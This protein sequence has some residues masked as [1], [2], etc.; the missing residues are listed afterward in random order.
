VIDEYTTLEARDWERDYGFNSHG[1]A[2]H[3]RLPVFPASSLAGRPIPPRR[4]HVPKIIP[5]Q[6]VTLLGGD[7]G[8]GKSLLAKQLAVSTALGSPWLGLPVEQGKALFLT[9]EDDRD[10]IHRRLADIVADLG[11]DL[12]QLNRLHVVTLADKDDA[13]LAVP[14]KGTLRT[15][16]LFKQLEAAMEEIQPCFVALDTLADLFGGEE[17][18]RAHARQ[19]ISLLRGLAI[20]YDCTI[21]LLTHPSLSGMASGSGTSGSTAWSNSV[22]SRLYLDRVKNEDGQE[23]DQDV[24]ILRVMKANYDRTGDEYKVR[25]QNG[26]FVSATPAASAGQFSLIAAKDKADAIFLDLVAAYEVEKRTVS[27][28][29]PAFAPNVFARDARAEGITKRGLT[30]AMNRLFAAGR[31]EVVEFGPPSH[32]RKRI[33]ITAGK[34]LE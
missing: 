33:A 16:P 5:A 20:R 17:N 28:A 25:W 19:F 3:Q 34:E 29:G 8:T 27:T 30:D 22:R 21:L 4:W 11:A 32:R 9:A 13:L 31:I 7:G 10:E 6:T 18:Q 26:V 2:S 14:E 15:T 23:T 24:R 1:A 12:G